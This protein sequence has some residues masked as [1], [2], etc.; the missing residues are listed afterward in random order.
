[1]E[2]HVIGTVDMYL[3]GHDHN[4]QWLSSTQGTELIVSGAAA[5][6]TDLKGRGNTTFFEDDT[7]EGFF[8]VEITEYALT[9][10]FYNVNGVLEYEQTLTF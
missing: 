10:R 2:T 3:C 4:R 5:K 1:M 9:G 7:V 8:W 6:T